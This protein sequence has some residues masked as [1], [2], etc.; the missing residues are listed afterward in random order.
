MTLFLLKFVLRYTYLFSIGDPG[1][2][3]VAVLTCIERQM[4][5]LRM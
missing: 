2:D 1:A 3:G 5:V 4:D